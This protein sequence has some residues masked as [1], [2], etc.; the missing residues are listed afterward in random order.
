MIQTEYMYSFR[1]YTQLI[2]DE[3][4]I[5]NWQANGS[6]ADILNE[7]LTILNL[8]CNN[9]PFITA[10]SPDIV[11]NVRVE[12]LFN[13]IK[14]RYFDHG[15]FVSETELPLSR[16]DL[17]EKKKTHL[18]KPLN[19]LLN[20]IALTYKKYD[21]LLGYYAS[22]EATL[23]AQVSSTSTGDS[24][25]INVNKRNETPQ[26]EG[27]YSGDTHATEVSRSEGTADNTIV[28]VTDKDTPIMRLAEIQQLYKNLLADW[29]DEM[30]RCFFEEEIV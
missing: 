13:L 15:F 1:E 25:T 3:T 19:N 18:R 2:L 10:T 4:H 17:K 20:K 30:E 23:L 21:L 16:D 8:S 27:D 6:L 29:S 5:D 11:L 7:S 24:S 26:N 12:E 22:K 28:S 9:L 14:A